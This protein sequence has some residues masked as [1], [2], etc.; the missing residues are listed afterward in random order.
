MSTVR[1]AVRFPWRLGNRFE[2][3][4]DGTIFVAR[5]LETI[6]SVRR[7]PVPNT[8][9]LSRPADMFARARVSSLVSDTTA[10][11]A[12]RWYGSVARPNNAPKCGC[13]ESVCARG[14]SNLTR[15]PARIL[16][17]D[18]QLLRARFQHVAPGGEQPHCALEGAADDAAYRAVDLERRFRAEGPVRSS[19][20]SE[21]A[22]NDRPISRRT[23]SGRTA[24]AAW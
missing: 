11:G 1:P 8:S 14:S 22:P 17:A 18:L 15:T 20:D 7:I 4:L 5:M 3:P 24:A 10:S 2:L 13:R 12:W 6:E 21:P 19:H 16:R 23:T 9:G